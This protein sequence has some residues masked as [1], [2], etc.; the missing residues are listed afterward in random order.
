[1]GG[2]GR[3]ISE[4]KASLVY[5]V[6]SR[7]TMTIQRDSVSKNKKKKKKKK[8]QNQQS[9]VEKKRAAISWELREVNMMKAH[10]T[11]FSK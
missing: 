11:H 10:I 4:F 5:R 9:C 1:L 6:S 2:R 7:A 8:K 3:R